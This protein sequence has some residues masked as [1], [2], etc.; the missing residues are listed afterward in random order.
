M[1]HNGHRLDLV[2][3]NLFGH[4]RNKW[5]KYTAFYGMYNSIEMALIKSKVVTTLQ[6]L[7]WQDK[8]GNHVELRSEAYGCKV[9]GKIITQHDMVFLGDEVGANL[10]MTGHGHIE[11]EIFISE[12]YFI[13]QIKQK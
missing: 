6:E 3:P 10:D 12:K 7:E 13:A 2:R 5:C 8:D 9:G 1:K 11:G 4:D